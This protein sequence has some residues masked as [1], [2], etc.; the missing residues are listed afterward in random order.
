MLRSVVSARLTA[1]VFAFALVL[2]RAGQAS[3]EEGKAAPKGLSLSSL[4][5]EVG[6]LQ[7]LRQFDFD[8]AQL[9]RLQKM[10]AASAAKDGARKAG[11]ASKEYR[12]KLQALRKALQGGGDL[13]TLQTLNE[14]IMKLREK[15][16]PFAD[17]RVE[18]TA[19]ARQRA[20]EAYRMLKPGQLAA[21]LATVADE[22]ADPLDRLMGALAHVRPLS[23]EE[24]KAQR[25]L[26][27]DDISQAAVGL[28]AAAAKRMSE[29]VGEFLVRARGLSQEQFEKQQGELEEA[30][31][32]VL[33][34]VT[35]EQV[36]RHQAEADLAWLLSNPRTPQACQ[37]LL[38]SAGARKEVK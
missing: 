9:E 33:G 8:P 4:S 19:A 14:E 34:D 1:T 13:E 37:A 38:R 35:A 31:R 25:G 29:R 22:L 2:G 3:A 27:A 24:W 17:D 16:K 6:A 10:A 15:E 26:I 11:K 5:L 12:D 28:D 18:V 30:A 23:D 7:A 36:L 20:V 32:K 21:Y